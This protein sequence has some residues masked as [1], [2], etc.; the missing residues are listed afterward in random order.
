MLVNWRFSE[1]ND[2]GYDSRWNAQ[3]ERDVLVRQEQWR[4]SL[5]NALLNAMERGTDVREKH[6]D[7]PPPF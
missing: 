7:R 6:G 1:T 2:A 4:K 3:S 5:A